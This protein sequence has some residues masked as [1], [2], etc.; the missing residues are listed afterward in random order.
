MKSYKEQM[1][2][3]SYLLEQDF[4]EYCRFAFERIQSAC[5]FLGIIN[6]EDYE[7]FKERCY[8]ELEA[9]YLNSIEKTIH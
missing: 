7:S 9:N 3:N 5:D 1:D 6:D 2:L 4:E 8:S